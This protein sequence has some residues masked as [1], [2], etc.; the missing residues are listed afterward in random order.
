MKRNVLIAVWAIA[1]A[2]FVFSGVCSAQDFKVAFVDFQKFVT[3]SHKAQEQQKKLVEMVNVKRT[4]LENKKKELDRL[5]EEFQKQGPML[6]EDTRTGKIKEMGI[7]EMEL[8]L[9]EKEAENAVRNEQREAEEIFRRDISK[10]IS[11]IRTEKKLTLVFNSAA[12]LAAD[13]ALDITD[14]V[15]QRY[16][17]EVG[18]A[19]AAAPAPVK[20]PAPAPA[21]P[22]APAK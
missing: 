21:K 2:A 4:A 19:K 6:K 1:C 7:K 11:T 3:K 9:A 15:A 12:L 8:K 5:Q 13:D 20:K 18:G 16:D 14:E 17:A 10:V 22:K